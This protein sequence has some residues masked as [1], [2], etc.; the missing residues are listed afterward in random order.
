MTSPGAALIC[1]SWSAEPNIRRHAI[2][3]PFKN[4]KG[5]PF[6]LKDS[7]LVDEWPYDAQSFNHLNQVLKHVRD[8][9]LFFGRS[10]HAL[11]LA[12]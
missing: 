7:S 11:S 2:I 5:E 12:P 9:A 6:E 8:H 4:V 10:G 1:R 3:F